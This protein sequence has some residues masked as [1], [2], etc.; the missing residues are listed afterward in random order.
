MF[1]FIYQYYL[2]VENRCKVHQS[3]HIWYFV[4]RQFSIL[5]LC[6]RETSRCCGIE[7]TIHGSA[8]EQNPALHQKWL[9]KAAIQDSTRK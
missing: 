6:K 7:D 2:F 9:I 1:P 5:D 8:M 4:L 3:E